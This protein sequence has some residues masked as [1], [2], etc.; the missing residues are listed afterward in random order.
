M[1]KNKPEEY[2]VVIQ[3]SIAD[4][5]IQ[6][7]LI[8]QINNICAEL[9]NIFVEVIVH[10]KGLTFILKDSSLANNIEK[11]NSKGIKFLV[12]NNSLKSAH[13]SSANIL[14]IAEI[15]PSGVAHLIKRQHEG[16]SYI[17]AG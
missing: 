14:T 10:S 8:N 3:L 5:E 13:L 16:W 4:V 12:C 6:K 15:I 7:A 2:K 11:L 1:N 17:K 9:T